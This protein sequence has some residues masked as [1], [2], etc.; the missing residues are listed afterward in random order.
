MP[1]SFVRNPLH[2]VFST[3]YR[4]PIIKPPHDEALYAYIAGICNSLD[5]TALKVG[6]YY[7]HVHILCLLSKKISIVAL[8]EEV[9]SSSSKWI[10]TRDESLKEFYWQAG[11]GAFAVSPSKV[12]A[13][14]KYIANQYEHHHKNT[15]EDEYRKFLKTYKIDY[16]E[17]YMWD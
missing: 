14:I 3:K 12:D 4:Q 7:D 15:F 11:Y 10:K 9:K 5:C 2:I 13:V 16:N 8:L 1:Q 6:G 17:D